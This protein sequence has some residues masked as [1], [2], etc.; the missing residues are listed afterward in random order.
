MQSEM[1]DVIAT[2]MFQ[3]EDATQADVTDRIQDICP[4]INVNSS[5]PFLQLGVMYPFDDAGTKVSTS[6]NTGT[7][8]HGAGGIVDL[9]DV[10]PT[11]ASESS[12]MPTP[13]SMFLHLGCFIVVA[14]LSLLL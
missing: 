14:G 9:S 8:S 2:R 5:F 1:L 4:D 10:D 12:A 11:G 13:V 6:S 3:G 7:E